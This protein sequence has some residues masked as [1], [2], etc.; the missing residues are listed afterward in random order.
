M[1]NAPEDKVM[2]EK[3]GPK[4][5]S[6]LKDADNRNHIISEAKA[7]KSHHN[8]NGDFNYDKKTKM[9]ALFT[10][11]MK[12]RCIIECMKKEHAGL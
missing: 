2:I 3:S 10:P 6:T 5:G 7:E 8:S 11:A 12:I 4:K 9:D 1:R